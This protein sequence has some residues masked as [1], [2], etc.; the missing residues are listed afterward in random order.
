MRSLSE[1][2]KKPA[3]ELLRLR[4]PASANKK[5]A[6]ELLRLRRVASATKLYQPM[7]ILAEHFY[8]I[9]RDFL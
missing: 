3:C 9:G 1:T 6:R 5:E 4:R 8:F 7:T 2:G